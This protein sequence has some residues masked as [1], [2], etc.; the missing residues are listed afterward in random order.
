MESVLSGLARGVQFV[1]LAAERATLRVMLYLIFFLMMGSGLGAADPRVV[2]LKEA[3]DLALRQNPDLVVARLDE[4]KAHLEVRAT[5]EGLLPRFILGSGLA[6]TSGMPMSVEGS[7]PTVVQARAVRS[8]YNAPQRRLTEMAR[9]E[10]VG[11]GHAADLV[12]EDIALRTAVLYLDLERFSRAAELALERVESLRKVEAAVR[13]RVAEGRELEI[14]GKRAA[15][16]LARA[17]QG[18]AALGSARRAQAQ[19]LALVLGLEASQDLH[20]AGEE[21]M[22]PDLPESE[23]AAVRAALSDHPDLKRL[24]A[25]IRAK[26]FEARAHREARLPKVDLLAQYGL[27]ARFNNYDQFFNRYQRHN[28]QFGASFAIPLFA[29]PADEA[30]AARVGVEGRRLR[31]ELA[32]ARGRIEGR[33]RD[34]WRQLQDAELVLEVARADLDLSREQVTVLL[35]QAQEGR[36][37]LAQLE[38]ARVAENE[39]WQQLGEA[40]YGVE[41]A[42]LELLRSA[43]QLSAALR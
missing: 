11:A 37:S 3:V 29:S 20:P 43:N 10:A 23:E 13:L 8:L 27:L 40:R 17:R 18:A 33:A 1:S 14:E 31:A 2:T 28:V 38:Q 19:A 5:Q 21:W 6:Y 39:K 35:A 30:R 26:G 32:Q 34:A 16:N 41:R 15:V 4:Q 22:N 9:A 7:A 12:R 25:A 24:E 42:R 36:A